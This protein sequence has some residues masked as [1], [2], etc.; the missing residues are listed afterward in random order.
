M[1]CTHDTRPIG[2][3]ERLG[4]SEWFLSLVPDYRTRNPSDER[5]DVELALF[6]ED[7]LRSLPEQCGE[8]AVTVPV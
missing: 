5:S 8:C 1:N 6:L 2:G 3:T 4:D 7:V